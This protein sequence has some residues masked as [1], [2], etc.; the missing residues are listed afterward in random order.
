M[1]NGPGLAL[2]LSAAGR[3]RFRSGPGSFELFRGW[4]MYMFQAL[5]LLSVTGTAASMRQH[6]HWGSLAVGT[7]ARP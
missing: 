1:G 5:V 4:T 2:L 6:G 7:G 3:G